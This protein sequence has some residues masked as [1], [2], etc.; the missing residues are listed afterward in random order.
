MK[1]KGWGKRHEKEGM[2]HRRRGRGMEDKVKPNGKL[3]DEHGTQ[4]RAERH[5]TLS[6]D[7]QRLSMT[8]GQCS[9]VCKSLSSWS[10]SVWFRSPT[11]IGY[12]RLLADYMRSRVTGF[13]KV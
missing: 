5:G 9:L 13:S 2:G 7:Y 4:K 6:M 3:A 11:T 12:V 1:G 8:Q 10:I